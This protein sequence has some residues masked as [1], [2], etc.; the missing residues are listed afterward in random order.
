MEWFFGVCIICVF[1]GLSG[2]L[3]WVHLLGTKT[4]HSLESFNV[5]M[6]LLILFALGS[7]VL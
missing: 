7:L 6:Y 2:A 1:S 5:A 4:E 3:G